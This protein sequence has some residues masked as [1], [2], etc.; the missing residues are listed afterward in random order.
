[1]I[2][3]GELF[4][5][6]DLLRGM[7]SAIIHILAKCLFNDDLYVQLCVQFFGRKVMIVVYGC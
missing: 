7:V 5:Q 2:R 3:V 1:M 4:A 6:R